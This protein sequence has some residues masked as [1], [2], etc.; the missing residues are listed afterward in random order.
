MYFCF[1]ARVVCPPLR[2]NRSKGVLPQQSGAR[3]VLCCI[4]DGRRLEVSCMHR[5]IVSRLS[6]L[7]S[8]LAS[9]FHI[10]DWFTSIRPLWSCSWNFLVVLASWNPILLPIR[11]GHIRYAEYKVTFQSDPFRE[12]GGDGSA[13]QPRAD[14]VTRIV[15]ECE[16]SSGECQL[17][18]ASFFLQSHYIKQQITFRTKDVYIILKFIVQF[19][20]FELLCYHYTIAP[21]V[22]EN[23]KMRT[24]KKKVGAVLF[25]PVESRI[26]YSTCR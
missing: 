26:D 10:L 1:A 24:V 9:P 8:S 15:S 22:E 2:A 4:G 5:Y 12:T 21:T 20:L 6:V 19:L 16:S 23:K 18:S 25:D 11:N 13:H 3:G 17:S 7:T 14:I